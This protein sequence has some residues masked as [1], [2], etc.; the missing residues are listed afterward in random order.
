MPALDRPVF[1]LAF[2][3]DFYNGDGSPKYREFGLSVLEGQSHV[4]VSNFAEH[5]PE[6]QPKQLAGQHGVIVLSPRVTRE[7]LENCGD[8]LAIGRFGVGYDSV[9]VAACT[10]ANV[11][12]MI[13]A[14]AVNHS[15]AEATVAW[16]L[17]LTHHL[18]VK[19]RLV[20]ESR[21]HDRSHFMGC[22]L[23]DRR[24][25]I[26]GF[27]G[28][29]RAIVPMLSGFRMQTPLVFDPF[30]DNSVVE[31]SGGK[32]VGLEELMSAADF[33]SINC[34]LTDATR[35]LIGRREIGLMKPTAYLINTARGGIIDEA[36][37]VE[38]LQTKAIAGAAL[39]CFDLEPVTAP[40]KFD[41]LENLHLAPHAVGWTHELFRDIGQT[42]CQSMLD[43]SQGQ[44]PHG[45]L[46]PEVLKNPAFREKWSRVVGQVNA[47]V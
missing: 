41:G 33:V 43:L 13:T 36:A 24:L 17:S 28:I 22:E 42:A 47:F 32:P 18:V 1:R 30:V 39:D 37:L 4:H 6:I 11:L 25:G 21:W 31:Q 46:N 12:A 16:M 7:S 29:G 10:K 44:R 14:G 38:A 40:E 8:L 3:G 19:D 15:M 34:P 9:D 2:T 35:G 5:Q 23:R 20:R 45:V 27:G 26:V